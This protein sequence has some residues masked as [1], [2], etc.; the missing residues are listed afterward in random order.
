MFTLAI[1]PAY[2]HGDGGQKFIAKAKHWVAYII[3]ITP[4]RRS[5]PNILGHSKSFKLRDEG[6][7]QIFNAMVKCWLYAYM[8][9]NSSAF[10]GLVF[11]VDNIRLLLVW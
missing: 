2:V 6:A 5:K 11:A 3:V 8:P 1:G 4:R 10:Y 7:H 9:F